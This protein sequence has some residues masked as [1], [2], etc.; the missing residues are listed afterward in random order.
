MD[1][2][3]FLTDHRSQPLN[4]SLPFGHCALCGGDNLAASVL[5][6][7]G[8]VRN[9]KPLQSG[10]TLFISLLVSTSDYTNWFRVMQEMTAKGKQPLIDW[11]K[12]MLRA[13]EMRATAFAVRTLNNQWVEL[14]IGLQ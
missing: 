7:H 14:R 11:V 1:L 8:L 5:A 12:A 4:W 3:G 6:E 10:D 9:H 13:R 2:W